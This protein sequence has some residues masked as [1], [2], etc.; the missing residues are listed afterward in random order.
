M[1]CQSSAYFPISSPIIPYF[2][3]NSISRFGISSKKLDPGKRPKR[4]VVRRKRNRL[5]NHSIAF[6][7]ASLSTFAIGPL[8]FAADIIV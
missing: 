3:K 1:V 4:T 6:A 5:A 8:I 2:L 7:T